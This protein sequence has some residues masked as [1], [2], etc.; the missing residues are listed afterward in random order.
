MAMLQLG[1]T[2]ATTPTKGK[3]MS[4]SQACELL[5]FTSP[6]TIKENARLASSRLSA[7]TSGVPVRLRVAAK[8]LIRAAK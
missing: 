7:F 5:G 8:V 4:Y 3:E 2:N 6:K 1:I